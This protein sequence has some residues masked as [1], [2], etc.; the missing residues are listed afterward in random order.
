MSKWV[1]SPAYA[2][3][4][5]IITAARE[6]SGL[7]QREVEQRLGYEHHGWLAR[8]ETRQRQMNLL[9]FIAIARVVGA[10]ERELFDQVLRELPQ[11]FDV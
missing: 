10:D 6:A 1:A 11:A 7:T 2:A 5:R 8:I 3:V 4:V 9:E